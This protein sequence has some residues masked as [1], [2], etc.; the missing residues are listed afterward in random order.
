M[1]I[2]QFMNLERLSINF[3]FISREEELFKVRNKFLVKELSFIGNLIEST[4]GWK[5]LVVG[6]FCNLGRLNE[7]KRIGTIRDARPFISK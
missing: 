1:G 4:L 7:I 5:E 2:E 3:N 6:G